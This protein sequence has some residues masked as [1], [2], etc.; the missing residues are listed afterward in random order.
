MSV[1]LQ[2]RLEIAVLPRTF[3]IPIANLCIEED[4][5]FGLVDLRTIT[6]EMMDAFYESFWSKE[7]SD[8]SELL[9]E[10]F[11]QLRKKH[12]GL[13][14]VVLTVEADEATAREQCLENAEQAA[15][16]LRV[17]H[18]INS[19]PHTAL[20]VRPLGSENLESYCT[21]THNDGKFGEFTENLSWPYPSYWE[22]AKEDYNQR[23]FINLAS[24]FALEDRTDYQQRLFDTLLIYS[25][26]NLA[27]EPYEKLIFCLVAIESMLLKDPSEPI[28]G[29]IGE[30]MAYLVGH[31]AEERVEIETLVKKVYSI[32]S[33][34]IHHGHRPSDLATLAHFMHRAWILFLHLVLNM[35]V[36]ESKEDMIHMLRKRKYQ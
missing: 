16:L 9:D 7:H 32:R 27:K 13:A 10:W 26:N 12:Q 5:S 14:A 28:Q 30:R 11:D 21:Y 2:E 22:I 17:M 24:L 23:L 20:Y 18:P 29:N 8:D 15:A 19:S 36:V 25:R 31:T 1:F 4:V 3:Y 33:R 35:D 34:F 6:S